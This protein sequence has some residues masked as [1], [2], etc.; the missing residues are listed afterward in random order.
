MSDTRGEMPFLDHLEELRWRIIYSLGALAVGIGVSLAL[1]LEYEKPI[2]FWLQ[3]PILPYLHGR[4]LMTTHPTTGMSILLSIAFVCGVLIALPV[5][6][7]QVWAFLSPALERREKRVVVPVSVGAVLLFIGGAALAWYLVL[8]MTL[9]VLIGIGEEAFDQMISASEY[10][11]FVTSLVLATGAAFQ[12]PILILLLTAL[13]LVTPQ[14]LARFR[15]HA[16]VIAF[17]A[18]ALI[19]PGDLSITVVVLTVLLYLLYELSIGLSLIVVWKRGRAP[20][21]ANA[22]AILL[23]PWLVFRRRQLAKEGAA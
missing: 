18:A 9:R 8:P 7:Y 4:R 16:F 10:F 12:L 1:L 13:G 17:A 6:V 14:F 5:I 23:V 15:R 21:D 22:A 11:D 20:W 3:G 19:V 2:L